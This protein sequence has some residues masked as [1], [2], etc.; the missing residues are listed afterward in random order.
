MLRIAWVFLKRDFLLNLSYRTAFI[1]QLLGVVLGVPL[2]YYIGQVFAGSQSAALS[3]YGGNYFAFLL[4]GVAFTDYLTVSLATFTTSIRENQMMGTLEIILLSPTPIPLFLVCSSLW[5]YLFTTVRFLMY[6]VIGLAFG[7]DLGH[8]NFLAAVIVLL[9]SI[10]C[11]A[12]LGIMTAAVTMVIKRGESVNL[13][14]NAV[15]VLL[16]GVAYPP[17]VL[18]SWLQVISNFLPITHALSG[19]RKALLQGQSL[20]QVL[21]EITALALFAAVLFPLGVM[22]FAK[23]VKLTKTSGTLG[24]Y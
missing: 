24:Q 16:G 4:I 19:M 20:I 3:E 13:L 18:P 21:P 8:A 6:L 14:I 23:A 15:S 9:M 1:L 10:L 11:F 22:G 7:L 2:F 17:S 5:G 12:S